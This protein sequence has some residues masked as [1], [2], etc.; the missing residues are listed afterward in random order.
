MNKENNK[1]NNNVGY[2]GSVKV[3]IVGS[4]GKLK[5]Q[6]KLKNNGYKPLFDFLA[7]CLL[8]SYNASLLPT[9]IATYNITNGEEANLFKAG[10]IVT[11]VRPILVSSMNSGTSDKTTSIAELTFTIPGSSLVSSPAT[12]CL[13]L[14]CGEFYTTYNNGIDKK[15]SAVVIL[16]E[17][18]T[19]ESDETAV[20]VWDLTIGNQVISNQNN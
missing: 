20:I 8:G 3:N 13:A 19:V 2:S 12:N 14:Y 17:D 4:K 9:Y 16:E 6:Y 5:K 1:S 10:A 18:F 11:C 15:P 7:H